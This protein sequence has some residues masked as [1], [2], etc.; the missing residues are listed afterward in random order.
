MLQAACQLR[1]YIIL[2]LERIRS[3]Q[4]LLFAFLLTFLN[5]SMPPKL[6]L[7]SSMENVH[8]SSL[9]S[10]F[11]Q[12]QENLCR[13]LLFQHYP[14]IEGIRLMQILGFEYGS[15]KIVSRGCQ[16]GNYISEGDL[17]MISVYGLING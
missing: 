16:R 10:T 2:L 14:I 8:V 15:A 17:K 5:N 1:A 13:L 6:R 9:D 7:K 11:E 4:Y 12:K 3:L